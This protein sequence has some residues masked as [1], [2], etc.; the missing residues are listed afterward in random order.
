MKVQSCCN[1]SCIVLMMYF[2]Y[3]FV[4]KS[5]MQ[6]IM[7]CKEEEIFENMKEN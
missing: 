4:K 5:S 2:M 3:I 6:Q 7:G 1:D